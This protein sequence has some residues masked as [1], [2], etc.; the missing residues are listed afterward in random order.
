MNKLV[1]KF[2]DQSVSDLKTLNDNDAHPFL[3]VLDEL[4][5]FGSPK[6]NRYKF[7]DSNPTPCTFYQSV[8][9]SYSLH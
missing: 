7:Y 6:T 5:I 1:S 4:A 8:T 9:A 3:F 2:K